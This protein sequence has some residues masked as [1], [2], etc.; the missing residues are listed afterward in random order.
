MAGIAN[1][2]APIAAILA[3]VPAV[4]P[5]IQIDFTTFTLQ[6]IHTEI[7]AVARDAEATSAAGPPALE[8]PRR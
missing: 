8:R 4:L 3:P 2:L 7:D 1:V 6:D 5:A